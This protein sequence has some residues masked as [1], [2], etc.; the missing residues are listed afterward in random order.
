[1]RKT[2]TPLVLMV[3]LLT[4]WSPVFAQT[5]ETKYFSE[6]GHNVSGD[7]LNFYNSA[8]NADYLYGYPITEQFTSKDGKN[9]QYFQRARFEYQA[10]LPEGQRVK[11]TPLGRE[12]YVTTGPLNVGNSF[13]CRTY[14][15][16]GFAVCFAFLEF[17][18]QNGGTTQFGFPISG[19]E[20][21]E[22]KIVQ[23]FENARLEWQPWRAEGLRVVIS[24]LGRA[25]FDKLGEDPALLAPVSPLDNAPRVITE[26]RVRAFVWKAV[27]LTNDTQ[28]IYVIVQDQ[29][30]QPVSGAACTAEVNW[31]NGAKDATTINSDANG[32]GIVSLA[33]NNQPYGSLIYTDIVCKYNDLEGK[34]TT[35]FRIWY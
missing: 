29:N 28:M 35:S 15:E 5:V 3:M 16:T 21:H 14:A 26:L 22:N 6:T 20:Y 1:M 18:D 7:L 32:V 13:A 33:F 11:L 25:Y 17:L 2:L 23:Y 4:S 24:D 27:T 34:T 8:P 30:M 12:T 31:S 10:D 19:F 9:V